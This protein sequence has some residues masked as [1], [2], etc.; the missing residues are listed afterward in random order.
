MRRLNPVKATA[1]K[2]STKASASKVRACK[3]LAAKARKKPETL[4]QLS[5]R[6]DTLE[7]MVMGM[8]AVS[9]GFMIDKLLG[10]MLPIKTPQAD[11]KPPSSCPEMGG[12]GHGMDPGP[13]EP[14]DNIDDDP[15]GG[16]I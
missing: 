15:S 9:A 5:R 12:A 16:P 10:K 6:V 11:E 3:R 4:A 8:M 14:T 13:V 2:V 7:G 1:A